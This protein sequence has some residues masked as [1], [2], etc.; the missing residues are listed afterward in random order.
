MS[1]VLQMFSLSSAFQA[2]TS[3]QRLLQFTPVVGNVSNSLQLHSSSCSLSSKVGSLWRLPRYEGS[4]RSTWPNQ[5]EN[6]IHR[7]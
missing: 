7:K 1:D 4:T 3:P 2:L 5:K 6:Y